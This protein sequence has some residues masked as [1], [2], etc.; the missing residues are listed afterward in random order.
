MLIRAKCSDNIRVIL[1][2]VFVNSIRLYSL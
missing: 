1:P 2:F